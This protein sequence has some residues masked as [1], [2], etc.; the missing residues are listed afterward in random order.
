MAQP[1][2]LGDGGS[3]EET[4]S[5]VDARHSA[6]QPVIRTVLTGVGLIADPR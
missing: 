2:R 4:N 5:P 3:A 1:G 6:V